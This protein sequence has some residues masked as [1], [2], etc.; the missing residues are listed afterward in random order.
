LAE[1]VMLL[2]HCKGTYCTVHC[3]VHLHT[4]YKLWIPLK[5]QHSTEVQM[6]S[7][8]RI[9]KIKTT[10]SCGAAIEH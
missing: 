8:W 1:T 2:L 9:H 6:S 7:N 5:T 4:N 3:L 10:Y